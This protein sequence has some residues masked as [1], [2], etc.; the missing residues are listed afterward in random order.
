M[1]FTQEQESIIEA[2]VDWYKNSS[3]QVFQFSGN[4]GTGKSVVMNE[5]IRRLKLN[6]NRV[7]PMSYVGAAA[8]NMRTKGLINAKTIHSWLYDPV[9]VPVLDSQGNPIMDTYFNTPL[10]ELKFR[11]K[12]LS[13]INLMAID[14]G[15][16]VPLSMRE[17]ILSRGKKVL[18][19]GDLDQ[20]MPVADSPA[21]LYSGK[22][23]VLTQ[24]MRQAE[25]SP[26]VYLCQRAKYG[27]P[28]HTGY[29]GD[30]LVIT[31]DEVTND[32]MMNSGVLLCGKNATRDR[33]N[34]HI[35]HNILHFNSLLPVCGE[36]VICRKNNWGI[37][38]GGINLTNGLTGVVFNHPDVSQF[39]GRSFRMDFMPDLTNIPFK[40]IPIDYE[41][42]TGNRETKNTIKST[43]MR[44]RTNLFE[45]GYSQT[46]H[47][48][49][50]SQWING[51]YY[52]EYLHPDTNNRLNYTGLSRFRKR[53]IYVKQRRKYI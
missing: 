15:G 31:E 22:V 45:F 23:H 11:P 7:A 42:F 24:I 2:A 40:D 44:G 18:V 6:I 33:L 37:E 46:V 3:E 26:I 14:E 50:G 30:V 29:Y 52:E 47:L 10:T 41:Y 28:I 36:K 1:I 35:R 39:D 27:L 5:I 38:C 49:Q 43:K 13:D 51:M 16:T 48:A 34:D 20:L 21:F 12:D 17:D 19:A 32:M 53:C 9:E 4:P 25:N 8:I